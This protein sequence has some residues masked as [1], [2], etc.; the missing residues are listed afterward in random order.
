MY[1]G[2]EEHRD[3]NKKIL[4]FMATIGILLA[5]APAPCRPKTGRTRGPSP[6]PSTSATSI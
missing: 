3:M 5:A 4:A 1:N 6:S 2:G